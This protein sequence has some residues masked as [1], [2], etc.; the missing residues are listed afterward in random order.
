MKKVVLAYSGGLDTSVILVWLKER[1][2]CEVVTFTA[3]LGQEEEL[4]GLEEK[5]LS[6]GASKVYIEDLREEFLLEY[7]FPTMMAGAIY[8]QLKVIAPWREWHIRSREDALACAE[9]HSVPVGA[10]ERSTYSHEGGILEEP[11][12]EPEADMFVLTLA[13][14]AAPNEP[15]YLGEDSFPRF[16]I[17]A[18]ILPPFV[19]YSTSLSCFSQKV[20]RTYLHPLIVRLSPS[21]SSGQ[22]HD[23]VRSPSVAPMPQQRSHQEGTLVAFGSSD[24]PRG[25]LA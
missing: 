20:H 14:E 22:A 19:D 15:L 11:W 21:A 13:P 23:E 5:A 6:T 16:P 2:G 4:G 7:T 12:Q 24:S 9:A 1:Y 3:D 8:E 10:T 18:I 25:T 17:R